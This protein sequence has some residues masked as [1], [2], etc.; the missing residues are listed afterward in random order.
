MFGYVKKSLLTE[1][2]SSI[3][4]LQNEL[5]N[6]KKLSS[7]TY[8]T[9]NSPIYI[10][11]S[12]YKNDKE[13]KI[14]LY[15]KKILE[16]EVQYK[17]KQESLDA[18]LKKIEM[19]CANSI[20]ECSQNTIEMLSSAKTESK[21]VIE[22]ATY[23]ASTLLSNKQKEVKKQISSL[24]EEINKKTSER[25]ELNEEVEELRLELN[26]LQSTVENF[27]VLQTITPISQ[28]MEEATSEEI[29]ASLESVKE[30][31]KEIVKLGNAFEI[32]H[33]MSFNNSSSKG[34]AMQ[35][36][37][38][39][40]LVKAFNAEADNLISKTN[41]KNFI[42]NAKKIESWFN[43]A[44]KNGDDSFIELNRNILNLRLK[45]QR[46]FF[47]HK[48][49]KAMELEEQQFM[50]ESIR[51]EA[52]V[53]KE[54]EKFI[55]DREKD[56]VLYRKEIE[57]IN[58]AIHIANEETVY[59]LNKK[60]EELEIKLQRATSEKERA[61]SMAQLTRSG[62]VYIISNKGSF[63]EN[64]Y[65]IGMTRRIEPL[66]RVKELGDASVP[67]YFDV[68][69]LI[70]SDD[71]PKLENQLHCKFNSRRVNKV[72]NR[73]EFFR[74]S[75][76]EIESA[77][78]ELVDEEFNLVRDVVSNQLEETLFIEEKEEVNG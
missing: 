36:R 55:S 21:L 13:R 10:E 25:K 43:T 52:K 41:S 38:G 9:I 48:Y 68:H 2:E 5:D 14:E 15:E 44:N 45:E 11:F 74:V 33:S 75:F 73:R 47:E 71:A 23:E 64:I 61:L 31:Q 54:I 7:E 66:D 12:S 67:F 77:L 18:K 62:Y 53:K 16:L 17:K 24:I 60:I 40:F 50:K 59:K 63:G 27:D 69:A 35:K 76:E 32:K 58:K 46:L 51:E 26:T 65:K 20:K 30:E 3:N 6:L 56:E 8:E 49:K 28:M 37:H 1:A 42:S 70:P 4:A 19:Q 72:N 78:N 22:K 57:E 29:K 39:K 34:K